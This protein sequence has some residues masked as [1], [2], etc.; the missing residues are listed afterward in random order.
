MFVSNYPCTPTGDSMDRVCVRVT[1]LDTLVRYLGRADPQAGLPGRRTARTASWAASGCTGNGT[2]HVGW[3]RPRDADD[4]RPRTRPTRRSATRSTRSAPGA[5]RPA[6]ALRR[7]PLG[8]LRRGGPGPAGPQPGL[9][10]QRVVGRYL[11]DHDHTAPT[12]RHTYGPIPGA[13]PRHPARR[14][15]CTGTFSERRAAHVAVAGAAAADPRRR[16][17][18]DRQPDGDRPGQPAGY[19]SVTPTATNRRRPRRSTSRSATTGP[20]T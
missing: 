17:G 5:L 1:E 11:G 19:V 13:G 12:R 7:Q 2:L 14:P 20:T 6:R 8:R 10:R 9:G 15:G 4:S 18:G 16:G 3:T